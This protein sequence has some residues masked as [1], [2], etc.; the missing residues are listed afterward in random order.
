MPWKYSKSRVHIETTPMLIEAA[1]YG[2]QLAYEE[3][4]RRCYE[5]VKRYCAA[6]VSSNHADD[7]TQECFLR[8]LKSKITSDKIESVE[9][10]MIH[11]AKFVCLDFIRNKTKLSKINSLVAFHE[12]E[13]TTSSTI[14]VSEIE[15]D[16]VCQQII[17]RLSENLKEA[18][19]LTQVLDFS[20]EECSEIL[21]IPIGT[22][23]SRV[24][25]AKEHLRAVLQK[26]KKSS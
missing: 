12:D 21:N 7:L 8:A 19:L 22:V 15:S 20:Y 10:F 1:K 24:S 18:F 9:G 5:P 26:Q 3:L 16:E 2:D 25:R 6:M 13:I 17:A 14:D 23:R 4:M 11:I